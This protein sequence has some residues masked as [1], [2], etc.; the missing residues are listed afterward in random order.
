MH[1]N[2]TDKPLAHFLNIEKQNAQRKSIS[3]E[4]GKILD[5]GSHILNYCRQYY[6]HLLSK[7]TVDHFVWDELM[8][9]SL[10]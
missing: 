8:E 9:A 5:N 6:A 2:S 10:D 7:K 3:N 4:E 1:L